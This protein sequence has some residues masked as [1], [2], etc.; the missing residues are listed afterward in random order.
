MIRSLK[1]V[2]F[3]LIWYVSTLLSQY[4]LYSSLPSTSGS[5]PVWCWKSEKSVYSCFTMLVKTECKCNTYSL[6]LW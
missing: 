4:C 2:R 6:N 1:L 5:P 3:R